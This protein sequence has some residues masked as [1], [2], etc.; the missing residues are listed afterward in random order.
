[1]NNSEE[2]DKDDLGMCLACIG[3]GSLYDPILE[4]CH[5]CPHC[6]CSGEA[7]SAENEIFLNK[8]SETI[9]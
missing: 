6:K 8:I 5:P 1:M 2:K 3:S 9:N 4:D 7:T